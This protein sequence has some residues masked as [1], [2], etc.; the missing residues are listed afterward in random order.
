MLMIERPSLVRLARRILGD[1]SS[2]EDI[3]QTLW[4]RVQRIADPAAI[5]DKRAY[6][7]RLALNLTSDQM[8]SRKRGAALFDGQ[9]EDPRMI[10]AAPSAETQIMHRQRLDLLA[11]AIN[12]LPP[13]CREVFLLRRVEGLSPAE[14]AERLGI[15]PNAVAKHVRHALNH[16]QRRLAE[17]EA[18]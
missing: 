12:E 6:L 18:G 2:A 3:A 10:D 14:V 1:A 4:L 5:K 8:R 17:R 15:T 7:Y 13:R 16:C 9:I 11:E